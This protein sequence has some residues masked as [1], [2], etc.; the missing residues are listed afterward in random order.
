MPSP[1][2]NADIVACTRWLSHYILTADNQGHMG[3]L[4]Q[5]VKDLNGLRGTFCSTFQTYD[6][7]LAQKQ[8]AVLKIS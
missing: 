8:W 5:W 4:V 2:S 3:V 7:P 1:T 6:P